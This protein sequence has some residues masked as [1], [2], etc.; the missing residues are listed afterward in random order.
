MFMNCEIVMIPEQLTKQLEEFLAD[1]RESRGGGGYAPVKQHDMNQLYDVMYSIIAAKWDADCDGDR[2]INFSIIDRTRFEPQHFIE[3]P[4]RH[5]VDSTHGPMP[6]AAR[7]RYLDGI[8][9]SCTTNVSIAVSRL[10]TETRVRHGYRNDE[11][12]RDATFQQGDVLLCVKKDE[13]WHDITVDN[14]Y[15]ADSNSYWSGTKEYVRVEH[16]DSQEPYTNWLVSCF[17]RMNSDD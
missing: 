9:D 13:E 5:L 14:Q 12:K 2:P 6:E 15:L 16:N 10:D 4:Y 3:I 7:Q 8:L 1:H 11:E 17:T